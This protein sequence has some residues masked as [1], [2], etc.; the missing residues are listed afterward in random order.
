ME[1]IDRFYRRVSNPSDL[2]KFEVKI[3]E[4]DLFILSPEDF[5]EDVERYLSEIR[6]D[7]EDYIN[8]NPIFFETLTPISIEKNMPPIAL[9]MAMSS[10][11]VG[12]G[13][14][15]AVAGAI[16]ELVG[17]FILNQLE[18]DR[19]E[20]IVENGGDIF[21]YTKRRRDV[22]IFAGES[23]LSQ[24]IGI[25]INRLNQP[26]GICTSSATVGPSKSFGITDACVVITKSAALSDA[27]ATAFG[28]MVKKDD[29]IER[30][31]ERAMKNPFVM[32][33]LIVVGDK[34]AASGDI[35]VIRF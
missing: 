2:I 34:F 27:A 4:S 18:E 26:L 25:R 22:M 31:A 6:R 24:R 33:I 32:G 11:Q 20:V 10:S 7:L 15:A 29:D 14:M 28:N 12:V 13:P 35:E 5:S 8:R 9:L 17:L 3:K 23:P 21:M 1:Y 30:V 16:A 19:K